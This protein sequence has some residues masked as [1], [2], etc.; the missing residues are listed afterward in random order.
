MVMRNYSGWEKC[1]VTDSQLV[2]LILEF[3]IDHYFLV[4]R[5]E[6]IK[7]WS[8]RLPEPDFSFFLIHIPTSFYIPSPS[9]PQA[10]LPYALKNVMQWRT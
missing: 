8:I 2:G 6:N 10:V 9:L 7:L 1:A 4:G 5:D 3:P